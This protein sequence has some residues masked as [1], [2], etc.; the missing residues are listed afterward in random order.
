M[1]LLDEIQRFFPTSGEGLPMIINRLLQDCDGSV[2]K[3]VKVVWLMS[4]A[5]T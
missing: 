4:L 5:G 2:E 3:N 1:D